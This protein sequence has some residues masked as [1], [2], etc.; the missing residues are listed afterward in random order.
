MIYFTTDY[1]AGAHPRVME[2]LLRTN[3]EHH[4]GY[5]EDEHCEGAKEL[6]KKV[7]G[8]DTVDI[9][10]MV[11]GTITNTTAI[12]AWLRPY[13][14]VVS[15]D[16][17]HIN[18][19]ETGAIESSGHKVL[20]VPEHEGKVL[21]ED[22]RK[23]CSEHNNEHMVKAGMLYISDST[24]LGT[25][26]T[27]AELTALR[28]VCDEC[29]LILFLDGARLGSALTAE[30]NDL[31]FEDLPKLCDAFY[32]GGTKNGFLFGEAMVIVR[33]DLKKNFR[34]MIKQR[35]GMFAKGRLIGVQFEEMFKD[36]LYLEVA[37]ETNEMAKLLREGMKAKGIE[38]LA[39]SP[40][41]QLFPIFTTDKVAELEK[42]YVFQHQAWMEDGRE[43]VRFVTSWLTKKEEIEE[44]LADL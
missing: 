29:G 3:E 44:L 28:E 6:L 2:A 10:L 22:V 9:H 19:H 17:G 13:E 34:Y 21:P 35:G 40:T 43:A 15:A 20:T 30:G 25:I 42:K 27:K 32:I 39:E 23:I 12:A 18:V 14:A 37:A 26:Y 11:G 16:T 36:N 33:E 31:T 38:F 8:D 41:N 24:E 4:N 5:F 7:I 1:S